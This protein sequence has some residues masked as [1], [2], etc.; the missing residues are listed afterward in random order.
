MEDGVVGPGGFGHRPSPEIAI[1]GHV[2]EFDPEH[3]LGRVVGRLRAP[4]LGFQT[5]VDH[6]LE[7]IGLSRIGSQ[8]GFV[9]VENS[10]AVGIVSLR[11]AGDQG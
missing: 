9:V 8:D 3:V 5:I 2:A 4:P 10:V 1:L 7:R 6:D 11:R